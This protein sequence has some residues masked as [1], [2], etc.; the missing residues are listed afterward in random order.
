[1]DERHR[2]T[3]AVPEQDRLAHVERIEELR[4]RL[5]RF[6]VHEVDAERPGERLGRSISV[7]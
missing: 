7:A 2:G 3:L 6:D 1:M 4:Q 5:E